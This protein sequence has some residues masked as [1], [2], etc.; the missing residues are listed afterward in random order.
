M[1]NKVESV[2]VEWIMGFRVYGFTG[3]GVYR[4]GF[5]GVKGLGCKV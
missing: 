3:S 1:E 5:A 4:S 2:I